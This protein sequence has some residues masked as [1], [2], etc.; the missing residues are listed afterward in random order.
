MLARLA[1][2]NMTPLRG[3]VISL[4]PNLPRRGHSQENLGTGLELNL[5][6]IAAEDSYRRR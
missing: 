5:F 6:V 2:I 1:T 4:I 3:A